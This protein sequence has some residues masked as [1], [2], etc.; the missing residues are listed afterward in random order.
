MTDEG[1]D[2]GSIGNYKGVML[3]NR[4]PDAGARP[5]KDGPS[6]F[7]SRVTVKEQIGL[8]PTA[9]LPPRSRLPKK[10]L[11]I[12]SRHKRWLADLAAQKAKFTNIIEDENKLAEERKKKLTVKEA[13]RRKDIL[14]KVEEPV[15]Y[16]KA[17]AIMTKKLSPEEL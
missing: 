14:K 7:I 3:C 10:N 6:P 5:V 2:R 17:K 1:V 9:Q 4:P 16:E 11:E 8:N 12:L 13:N 15:D